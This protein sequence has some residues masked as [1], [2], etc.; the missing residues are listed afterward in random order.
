M[1]AYRRRRIVVDFRDGS[2]GRPGISR[3]VFL[4]DRQ[5]GANALD[6]LDVRPVNALEKLPCIGGQRSDV[7]ALPFGIQ[8]VE[9]Q[10]AFSAPGYS[11]DHSQR[12]QGYLHR[13]VLQVVDPGSSDNNSVL[14]IGSQR[15]DL[16]VRYISGRQ[17]KKLMGLS[18]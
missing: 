7:P 15:R 17:T 2:H 13:D 11:G 14:L 18:A 6:I 16:P 5:R 12:I 9:S 8:R 3:I 4:P 1:R 10:T